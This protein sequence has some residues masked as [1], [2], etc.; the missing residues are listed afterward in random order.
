MPRAISRTG[1]VLAT[2]GLMGC[3]LSAMPQGSV[4]SHPLS[5]SGRHP[6]DRPHHRDD[7]GKPLIQLLLRDLSRRR[8]DP[9]ENGRPAVCLPDLVPSTAPRHSMIP[10]T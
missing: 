3:A 2:A 4:R 10:A 6:E 9:H 5:R 1:L 8:R 7:A